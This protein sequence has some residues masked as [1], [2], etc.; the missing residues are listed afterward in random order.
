LINLEAGSAK[1]ERERAKFLV[2]FVKSLVDP[3]ATLLR[4]GNEKGEARRF[5]RS[6]K[7]AA[8]RLR[9]VRR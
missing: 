7:V 9:D 8:L 5:Y 2:E 1:R 4:G 6:T 3:V